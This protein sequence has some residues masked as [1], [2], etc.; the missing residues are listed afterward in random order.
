[1]PNIYM[2]RGGLD[3][4][5]GNQGEAG[6]NVPL[7]P[8]N[9]P[10]PLPGTGGVVKPSGGPMDSRPGANVPRIPTTPLRPLPGSGPMKGLMPQPGKPTPGRPP[11]PP[12]P[13]NVLPAQAIRATGDGKGYDPAFLQNLATSIG[14]LFSR[15]QGNLS[16]N[17]LGNLSEISP[18]SGQ[19]GNAPGFGEPM[20]WLQQALN[21]L[22]FMFKPPVAPNPFPGRGREDG[23]DNGRGR[24]RFME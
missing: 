7:I 11:L 12:V 24:G 2:G 8:T 1:M 13:G 16:F 5:F 20:T 14:A 3:G 22:A 6:S 23:G 9:P 10:S 18:P 19:M 21:G 4:L 15:P 17:P